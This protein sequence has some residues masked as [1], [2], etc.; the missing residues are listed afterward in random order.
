MLVLAN[1]EPAAE[2]R[3]AVAERPASLPAVLSVTTLPAPL[4][5]QPMNPKEWFR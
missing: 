4:D 2:V 1:H 3:P 5:D